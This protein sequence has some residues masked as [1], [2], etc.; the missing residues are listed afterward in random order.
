MG[1]RW[2]MAKRKIKGDGENKKQVKFGL[3]NAITKVGKASKIIK[4]SLQPNPTTATELP[5]APCAQFLDGDSAT[6]LGS[7][8]QCLTTPSMK[9]F[10]LTSKTTAHRHSQISFV[11][12]AL[13]WRERGA[14]RDS[15]LGLG[16]VESKDA[17][18]FSPVSVEDGVCG[19]EA[20]SKVSP[21]ALKCPSSSGSGSCQQDISRGN[22]GTNAQVSTGTEE[23]LACLLTL[24]NPTQNQILN[25]IP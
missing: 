10:S 3:S 22:R 20:V 16:E 21:S 15:G 25:P 5:R 4:S 8:F 9:T 17:Q 23:L 7:L 11:I 19:P 18:D 1:E 12:H 13:V 6:S 24:R 14:L 2:G